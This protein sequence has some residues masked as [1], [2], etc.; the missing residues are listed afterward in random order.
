MKSLINKVNNC[1]KDG[2]D[3]GVADA[4]LWAIVI[5][6]ASWLTRG[7]ENADALFIII[8]TASTVAFLFGENQRKN[9]EEE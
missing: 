8:I 1:E 3:F 7:S 9:G 4:I 2:A 6:V 5:L